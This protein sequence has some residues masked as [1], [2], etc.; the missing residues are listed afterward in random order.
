[1]FKF[2]NEKTEEAKKATE[3]QTQVDS[4]TNTANNLQE[5]IN[6]GLMNMHFLWR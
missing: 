3:L 4:L 1:M 6:H 5:K 2:Y